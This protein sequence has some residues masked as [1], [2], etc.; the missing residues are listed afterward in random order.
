MTEKSDFSGTYEAFSS[1]GDFCGLVTGDFSV[2]STLS[3]VA[4]TKAPNS[5][6]PLFL[7]GL[8][9]ESPSLA[10]KL[11]QPSAD[12]GPGDEDSKGLSKGTVVE[13]AKGLE[14]QGLPIS[15]ATSVATPD[16]DSMTSVEFSR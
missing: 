9:S 8:I 10:L 13:A 14:S 6:L 16:P 3:L 15:M 7:T 5:P 11:A 1:V 4:P 12:L 2:V